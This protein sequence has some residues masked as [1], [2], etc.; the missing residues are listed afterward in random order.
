[1]CIRD[2]A[3]RAALIGRGFPA[4][5]LA[6]AVAWLPEDSRHVVLIAHANDRD[7]ILDNRVGY[8]L[9]VADVSWRWISV[10]SAVA[11]RAWFEVAA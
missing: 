10:Q 1:M 7:L 3:K 5:R 4:D 9:P 8:V 6:L 11:P 2:R